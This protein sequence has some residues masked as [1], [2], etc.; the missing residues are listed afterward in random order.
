MDENQNDKNRKVLLS[1][2]DEQ[3]CALIRWAICRSDLELCVA[4]PTETLSAAIERTDSSVL[5]FDPACEPAGLRALHE[6]RRRFPELPCLV[7]TREGTISDAVDAIRAGAVDYL[8]APFEHLDRLIRSLEAGLERARPRPHSPRSLFSLWESAHP[9]LGRAL[10]QLAQAGRFATPALIWGPAGS[11]KSTLAHALHEKSGRPQLLVVS[12][13]T[14]SAREL[15]FATQGHRSQGGETLLIENLERLSLSLQRE[16]STLLEAHPSPPRLIITACAPTALLLEQ[17]VLEA[18]LAVWLRGLEVELLQLEDR[19]AD[20]PLLIQG[21]LRSIASEH[22]VPPPPLAP[23]AARCLATAPWAGNLHTLR[24]SLRCAFLLSEGEEITRETLP[25]MLQST[26]EE[27][28]LS[29]GETGPKISLDESFKE[30]VG[31]AEAAIRACYLR[32]VLERYGTVSAAARHA[33][34]DRANFRRMM[35]RYDV[36]R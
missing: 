2:N 34:L 29:P 6:L 7:I 35:R 22:G 17:G 4:D 19:R 5:L 9:R 3:L 36:E 33:G 18:Q 13:Q 16:L 24:E 28:T 10:R 23:S 1:G 11:G 30:A 32:G 8:C 14:L 21:I 20:L 15:P 25:S 26:F 12:Q 27:E 31:R